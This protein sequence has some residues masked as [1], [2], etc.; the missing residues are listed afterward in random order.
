MKENKGLIK[1]KKELDDLLVSL[2]LKGTI[3][4]FEKSGGITLLK[5]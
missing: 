4:Y 2:E 1:S 3:V 5:I